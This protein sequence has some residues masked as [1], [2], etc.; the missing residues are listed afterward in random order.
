MESSSVTTKSSTLLF[1]LEQKN[2][3]VSEVSKE[4]QTILETQYKQVRIKGEL[5][6]VKLHTS[7]HLY[8]TLK[9]ADSTLDGVCWRG[10]V[11]K[12]KAKPR[13]GLEVVITGKISTFSARS[14]YLVV[15]EQME[16]FGVGDLQKRFHELKERL[17]KEGLFRE[18]LKK[19]IPKIP[20]VI[21][22]ITSPTGAV[23]QDLA[24]RLK[25]RY[26]EKVLI[27][28]SLVQGEGSVESVVAAI[29]GFNMMEV[30]PDVLIIARG[31]G[32]IEDLWTFNEEAVIRAIHSSSIPVISAVGH[33]TDTTLCDLIADLRSPTPSAA[34]EIVAPKKTDIQLY[35]QNQF[36]LF[37]RIVNSKI[38]SLNQ[39]IESMKLINAMKS[40]QQ[41][42]L[43][44][45]DL[46][47]RMDQNLRL[48]FHVKHQII[49]NKNFSLMGLTLKIQNMKKNL[50]F[51][52]VRLEQLFEDQFRKKKDFLS[53]RSQMLEAY[54][55]KKTLERGFALIRSEEDV[56]ISSTK[57]FSKSSTVKIMFKDGEIKIHP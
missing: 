1:P 53:G 16:E 21:A 28:P 57:D 49:F 39:K 51:S 36:S 6:G 43:K 5:S 37:F 48:M 10:S 3:S 12:L 8:Y 13:D 4:I 20:K 54:S 38:S 29:H 44:L 56:V 52:T 47:S 40:Q 30:K 33:E 7:G 22:I 31:G 26:T 55:F 23:I 11:S 34:G 24:H 27:W 35:L 32:S 17:E 50:D 15:A 19:R 45:D 2:Y 41:K 18:E 14:K 9:D 42:I 46:S 25:E